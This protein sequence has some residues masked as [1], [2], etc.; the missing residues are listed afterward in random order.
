MIDLYVLAAGSALTGILFNC[1]IVLTIFKR[2]FSTGKKIVEKASTENKTENDTISVVYGTVKGASK[3]FAEL[4]Y[5]QLIQNGLSANIYDM[6]DISDPEDFLNTQAKHSKTMV[7]FISTYEDVTPPLSAKWFYSYVKEAA[8]DFR[9]S[10]DQLNKLKY[11]I[12]GCGNSLY[13]TNFNKIAINLDEYLHELG[14]TKILSTELADENTIQSPYGGLEG[15]YSKWINALMTTLQNKCDSPAT[16]IGT[17][18]VHCK[19]PESCDCKTNEEN[20]ECNNDKEDA[21]GSAEQQYESDDE[22]A[23]GCKDSSADIMDLEDMGHYVSTAPLKNTVSESNGTK[24]MITPLIRQ[25][26]EKQGYKLIGSHSGVK[27]C[28]WTKSMLRGRGGCYKHTFYGIESHRCM[29]TTPSLACANKCVFCWRHHTNPVGTSWQWKTDD[30]ETLYN[31]ATQNHYKMIKEFRGVPGVLPE[32]YAEAMKIRHCALSLVGEPIMYPH[33]NELISKLHKNQISTFLVTNAQFPK[34]IETLEPVTQ[35]YVS[36]DASTKE[37]LKKIDRPLF[38][39]FWERYLASLKALK[40]KGQRTVYRLT[41]VKGYNTEQIEQYA[42][43]VEL[44]DPDFIEVK[45]VTY[46]GE[47]N[48]STLTLANVPWHDEVIEFVK[49]LCERLPQYDIAC[50]HEHS[51][52]LLLAHKKFQ[53]NG[54]WHTWI[55]YEKFHELIQRYLDSN[56][57]EL[58][59][60]LDY[61]SETPKWAVI[62]SESRGF[63]PNDTRKHCPTM[64]HQPS[65]EPRARIEKM[66]AEV[67]DSNPYSRL[68]ALQRMGIRIREYSVLIV[69][70]GGVG[71]VAA[72]MLTRCGC[73]KLLLFDYDKVELANMNRLFYQP[74]QAGLSKVEAAADTLR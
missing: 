7:I 70:V 20:A 71:S 39:D 23:G 22:G 17:K 4:T 38:K 54:I 59:T 40:S 32:R 74:H 49:L 62:G 73:G 28:R 58:F 6:K 2:F 55:N 60:S 48:A 15:H 29:E 57:T 47:S 34:E 46:C 16:L 45:G 35:L 11:S 24:E 56:K 14:S 42:N 27:I 19:N 9:V 72:E 66:S 41:L 3:K 63:D 1:V 65:M 25:S 10:K 30:A 64:S 69:G 26:L 13:D 50:E 12:F 8:Y 33:I 68:M 5:E 51:N 53:I 18:D 43:L 67:V 36:V 44:G 52:C 31:G 37:T 21:D 61:V